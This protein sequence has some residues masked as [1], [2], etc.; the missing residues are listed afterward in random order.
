MDATWFQAVD[1][2]ASRFAQSQD[3]VGCGQARFAISLHGGSNGGIVVIRKINRPA[4]AGFN[5]N[6]CAQFYQFGDGCG[7]DS[8][9]CFVRVGFP[10]DKDFHGKKS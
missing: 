9:S 8:D 2:V 4:Q 6:L 3:Q 7:Y 10:G 1:L 5:F